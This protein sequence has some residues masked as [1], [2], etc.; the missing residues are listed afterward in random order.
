M[1][2]IMAEEKNMTQSEAWKGFLKK[3]WKMALVIIAGIA[4]AFIGAIFVFL[5]RTIGIDVQAMYPSTLDLWSIGY[6]VSIVLDL[7]GWLFLLIVLP[8]IA[9]V[10]VLYLFW[11]NKFPEE[12]KRAY[13]QSSKDASTSKKM[14][15][16]GGGGAFNFLIT[17]TWLIIVYADGKWNAPFGTWTFLYLVNSVLATLL[18][19]LLIIGIPA[20]IA[21][22]V[23]LVRELKK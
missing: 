23:W 20:T 8:V 1:M 11:W 2:M 19:D 4:C 9:A 16:N 5:W 18:W 15:R 7:L 17:I 12:E 22:V 10:I 3:H 14:K 13:M 21:L 6:L